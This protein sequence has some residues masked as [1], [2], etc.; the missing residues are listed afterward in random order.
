LWEGMIDRN[1]EVPC[2]ANTLLKLFQ[3]SNPALHTLYDTI[4]FDEG[5]D[6][7]PVTLD[8]VMNNS[9]QK[10]IV[11]DDHQMINRWRGA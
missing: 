10:I 4:L 3:L 2:T 8:I 9:C 1:S 7:N 11:G 5:Q 6:A